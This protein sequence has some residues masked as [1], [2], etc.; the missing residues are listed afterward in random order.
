MTE[1]S[2]NIDFN[3]TTNHIDFIDLFTAAHHLIGGD[4]LNILIIFPK[5]GRFLHSDYLLIVASSIN[6]FR[7]KGDSGKHYIKR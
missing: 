6:F 7:A 2:L 1:L 5:I 3:R 4:T